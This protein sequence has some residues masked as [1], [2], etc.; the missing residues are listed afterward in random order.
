MYQILLSKVYL[1]I[2]VFE[3]VYD[4][5]FVKRQSSYPPKTRHRLS[6]TSYSYSKNLQTLRVQLYSPLIRLKYWF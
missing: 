4:I 3:K 5:N 6:F 2:V 1:K